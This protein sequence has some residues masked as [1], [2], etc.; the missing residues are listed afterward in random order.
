MSKLEIPMR[1]ENTFKGSFTSPEGL[2]VAIGHGGVAPYDMLFA[3]L[4]SCLHATF[5]GVM[6]K[7]RIAFDHVEMTVTGEK[8]EA[9]PT[10][11]SW[12]Q[13]DVTIFG[14][15]KTTGAEQAFELATAYCSIYYTLS[16]VADMR[17][18]VHFR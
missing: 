16:Q 12:V 8:R 2:E 13:V 14:A 17:Y 10:H 3:A 4:G 11:L 7:K 18:V 9:V 1:F 5:L 6:L 15:E